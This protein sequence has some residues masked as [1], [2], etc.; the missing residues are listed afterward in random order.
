MSV[1][2]FYS[3]LTT[4]L[5]AS[6]PDF[7]EPVIKKEETHE[8]DLVLTG[9]Q[10]MTIEHTKFVVNG[11][12]YMSGSSRLILRQSIIE[13]NHYPRQ[14]IFLSDSSFIQADTTM[15]RDFIHSSIED[16]SKLQNKRLTEFSIA[17]VSVLAVAWALWVRIGL[18]LSFD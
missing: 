2:L 13:V 5:H 17:R 11:N 4:E 10:A 8:G 1:F 7:P 3:F 15:F 18:P 9:T 12:I 16:H 14:E 6:P